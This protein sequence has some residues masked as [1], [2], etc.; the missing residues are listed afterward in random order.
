[1]FQSCSKDDTK[2]PVPPVLSNETVTIEAGSSTTATITSGTAP[3]SVSSSDNSKVT[4]KIDDRTIT[5]SAI[6]EGQAMLTVTGKD[7]ATAKMAVMVNK[8]AVNAPQLSSSAVEIDMDETAKVTISGGTPSFTATSSA[9]AVAT[10]TVDGTTVN[11]KGITGGTALIT[12]TGSDNGTATFAV[13]VSDEQI[14]FGPSK[15]QLGNGQKRFIIKKSHTIRKGVYTMVGWIYVEEGATLTI[16]PGTII[17]GSDYDFNDPKTKAATGS[18]LIIKRGAKIHAEGTATDPIVFTSAKKKGERQATDWGG[19][20]ICGKAKNNQT[21]ATV[22][23]GVEAD[24]GGDDD[25]DNSGVL[26]YVRIEFAGY[27]Y[28]LDNEI[29]GLTLGSVG[30]GTTIDHIQVSYSGD[31]SFEW[32][33]GTVNCK[34]L[35]AFHGWDDDFDTDFGYSGKLQ[36]LLSVRD[37]KIA[38]QSNSNSFES[39]N[40][41]DGDTK[42]PFTSAI[43]S[44]VTVI[45]P[46]GQDD[47]FKNESGSAGYI[48]GYNWGTTTDAAYPIRPGIFQAAMQIRRNSRLSCFNSVFAGYPV[49]LMLSNEKGDTQGA[50]VNGNLKIKNVFFAGMNLIGADVD[51][52]NPADWSGNI[53]SDYFKKAELNNTALATIAEL[54]LNHPFSKQRP[55][56]SGGY[57]P[58]DPQ[59]NFAPSAGSPLLG[60]ADFTDAFLNDP[61]FSKVTYI[62]AFA[63]DA[64]ADNWTKG[65]ANFDPQNTDY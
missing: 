53:S 17:K 31:D 1:M 45:G 25:S 44:N 24:Y 21:K 11:V 43:F 64:D 3:F 49:G 48:N 39:D 12:V 8:K 56:R 62:G 27:P 52:K 54:K 50:A 2:D 36:F 13:T 37:P 42:A 41:A 9:P 16:E 20:I 18:S 33:G 59:A 47:D 38:D 30:N 65:W 14:F 26:R 35:I 10:V 57:S 6:A 29:N 51:K 58:N 19:I 23:G 34:N 4:A 7:N 15:T 22:E 40:N 55:I 32:F 61:F 46:I 63:S 5:I 28:A 60:K